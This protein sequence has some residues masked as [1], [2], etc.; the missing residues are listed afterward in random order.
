M[1]IRWISGVA[2]A[3]VLAGAA[4]QTYGVPAQPGSS[5]IRWEVTTGPISTSA[6][7]WEKSFSAAKARAGRERKPILLLHL[8][9]R[10][11]EDMC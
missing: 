11:D 7:S 1:K 5:G 4:I 6:I 3:I 9:G 2:A 8:F 10:L